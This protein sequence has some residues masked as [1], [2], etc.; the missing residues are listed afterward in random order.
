MALTGPRKT[1]EVEGILREIGVTAGVNIHQGALVVLAAGYAKP[2]VTEV[3]A[4]ALGRAEKPAD[5]SGGIAGAVTVPIKRGVFAFV[6]AAA[7]PL[8]AADIGADCFIVDDETVAKT[9]GTGTRSKA[10]TVYALEGSGGVWV[11]IR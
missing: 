2:G 6:N 8:T 5:N 9:D 11:E 3:G 7:D 1:N 4:V 10:G